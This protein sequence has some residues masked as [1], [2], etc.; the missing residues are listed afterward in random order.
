MYIIKGRVTNTPSQPLQETTIILNYNFT[1]TL[2]MIHGTKHTHTHTQ[3]Y[4]ITDCNKSPA[5]LAGGQ[6]SPIIGG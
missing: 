4:T 3:H 6:Y 1:I 5:M 2:I